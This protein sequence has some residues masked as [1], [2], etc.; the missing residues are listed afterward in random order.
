M[1]RGRSERPLLRTAIHDPD[2]F[3]PTALQGSFQLP[4]DIRGGLAGQQP[5]VETQ[6]RAVG[7][8][9]RGLS[10]LSEIHGERPRPERRMR[11]LRQLLV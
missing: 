9:V 1:S 11:P 3:Y 8:D 7:D 10:A 2:V 6:R 4:L 5:P